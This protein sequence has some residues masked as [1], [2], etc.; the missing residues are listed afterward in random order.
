MGSIWMEMV[1]CCYRTG[2]HLLVLPFLGRNP[3]RPRGTRPDDRVASFDAKT[4]KLGIGFR[5][6]T[7][8]LTMGAFRAV[9]RNIRDIMPFL[10]SLA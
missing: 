6:V 2:L 5:P 7:F 4:W 9:T 1:L 8:Q 10:V 3:Q